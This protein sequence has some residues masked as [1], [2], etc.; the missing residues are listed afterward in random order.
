MVFDH[1]AGYVSAS[2]GNW[3][4][5]EKYARLSGFPDSKDKVFG[6]RPARGQIFIDK[7]PVS[8]SDVLSGRLRPE[9]E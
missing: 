8:I 6:A 2:C 4:S 9:G 5:L 3:R 1:L 7:I